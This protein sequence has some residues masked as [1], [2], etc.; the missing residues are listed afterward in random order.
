MATTRPTIS[1]PDDQPRPESAYM[2]EL[3]AW[4]PR[5]PDTPV[6]RR[7]SAS[8]RCP[9]FRDC[10]QLCSGLVDLVVGIVRQRGGGHQLALAGERFV[11]LVS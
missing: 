10:V 1:A 7:T 9:L 2:S 11:G 5:S 3:S 8:R 4:G 6:L